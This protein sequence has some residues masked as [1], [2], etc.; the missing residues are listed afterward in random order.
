M[1]RRDDAELTAA[2]APLTETYGGVKAYFRGTRDPSVCWSMTAGGIEIGLSDY[3]ADAPDAVILEFVAAAMRKRDR[4]PTPLYTEW[5]ACEGFT[6]GK[7]DL[8]L[9]RS[10]NL[11]GTPVGTHHDLR[12]A[13]RRLID[14]DLIGADDVGDARFT[15]TRRPNRQRIGYCA[16]SMRVI[17][18]SCLLDDPDVPEHVLDYV[19]FHEILHLI[20]SPHPFRKSHDREFNAME[21]M[22][23]RKEEAEMFLRHFTQVPIRNQL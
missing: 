22:F 18:V 6:V 1:R 4:P 8:F 17:A 13:V 23:P 19:V 9:A 2:L 20:Q 7:Q 21:A 15:W 12:D 11:A 5:M 16:V 14:A 3:L 10:R